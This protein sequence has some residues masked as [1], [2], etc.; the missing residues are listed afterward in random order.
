MILSMLLAGGPWSLHDCIQYA[1]AHNLSI[2][3]SALKV[4][5]KKIALNTAKNRRLPNLSASATPNFS[6]GRGLTAD[7]TYDNTNTVS[8]GFSTGTSITIYQ[9]SDINNN[10]KMSK[11]DLAASI[12]DLEKAKNDIK[13]AI[14]GAYSEVLYNQEILRVENSQANTDSLLLIRLDAMKQAGKVNASDVAAQKSLL[15][16][17]K[18]RVTQ[19]NNNLNLSILN[20]TQLL[21][22]ESPEDFSIVSPDLEGLEIR[23]LLNPDQIFS[24]AVET[25]PEIKAEELRLDYAKTTIARAKG[26]YLPIISFGGGIES[27]Y[28]SASN[29]SSEAFG[30]QLKNNFSQ[31]IGLSIN[32]PIFNRH[33]TLNEVQN[34]KIS[35]TAQKLELQ[36]VKK[37]LYKEIQQAYYNALASISKYKSS[38][39]AEESALTSYKFMQ[40]KYENG[41]ANVTEYNESKNRYLEAEANYLQ[42]QYEYLY[43]VMLLD[44]YCGKELDF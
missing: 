5:Q 21:E 42:A 24:K 10:I 31:Y 22:L 29:R 25:K 8:I 7:N 26:G 34:A 1:I 23:S 16:Q 11:L 39:E 37:A 15:Y 3:Q 30:K 19:A 20:L 4:E 14:A 2:Q 9:G 40:A 35:Y 18:L 33:A 13:M 27:N 12:S 6:F 17:S 32:V 43:M 38:K 28:Y 41:K 44:F 36:N